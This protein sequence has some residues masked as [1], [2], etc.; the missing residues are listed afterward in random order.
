[1]A[2]SWI[3]TRMSD[4]KAMRVLRGLRA[5]LTL[6]LVREVPRR[7]NI[8]CDNHPEYA[9]EA[10]PLMEANAKAAQA[11]KGAHQTKK[12][13]CPNGHSFA[14]HGRIAMHK[15]FM[16]RQC[17]A[18][19]RV[20]YAQGH[21]IK[22]EILQQVKARLAAKAPVSSFTKA[23][24]GGYLVRFSTL[25]RYRRENPEFD[26]LVLDVIKGSN[27]RAQARRWQKIKNEAVREQ[28][29]DYYKIR[30]MLPANFPGKDDVVGDI[31]EALLDGSL[32]RE[33][34]RA[35]V[36]HYV[37]AYNRMF[38]TNFAKFGDGKL[39]SLDEVLFEGAATTRG[40]TIS[41]GL[42]D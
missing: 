22:P 42:W 30:A 23:G 39:V 20:R 11:R 21:A 14:E 32:R 33:D 26:R 5:G 31:F 18:C 35:R 24:S 2:R 1:M 3:H 25:A 12:T 13:H 38:P 34:V 27:S 8:Y 28:N 29:N 6:R 36:S 40:D 17:R 7:F 9:R 19:E 15:G 37:A 41:R 16:S 10:L 4:E